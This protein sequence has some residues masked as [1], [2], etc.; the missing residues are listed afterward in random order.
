MAWQ[1]GRLDPFEMLSEMSS[2]LLDWWEAWLL[3]EPQGQP[4]EDARH[5]RRCGIAAGEAPGK[6][7][8]KPPVRAETPRRQTAAEQKAAL[9]GTR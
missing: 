3:I 1:F 5:A 9:R 8:Y 4:A 6:F 2:D 7:L